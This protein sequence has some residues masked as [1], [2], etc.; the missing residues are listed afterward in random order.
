MKVQ[1][2]RGTINAAWVQTTV[3]ADWRKLT[4]TI[5]KL[6]ASS[7]RDL[8]VRVR[9]RLTD[10][11]LQ[12]APASAVT[13]EQK[14]AWAD[15]VSMSRS[16]TSALAGAV[17]EVGQ[18]LQRLNPVIV[19][20]RVALLGLISGNFRGLADKMNAKGPDKMR[21][22]WEAFGGN[23]ETLRAA[24]AK[25]AGTAQVIGF[26]PLL[27][28][29][30]TTLAQ[31]GGIPPGGIPAGRDTGG[32]T[33]NLAGLWKIAEPIILPLLA[34]LGIGRNEVEPTQQMS[35]NPPTGSAG[36]SSTGK[37]A[38]LVGGVVVAAVLLSG[39]RK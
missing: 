37:T 16:D 4:E 39:K 34:I 21:A 15:G 30:I 8:L 14:L 11:V 31:G 13:W 32:K 9:Q 23:Y 25:G 20:A 2:I 27:M 38:L 18:A 35:D 22:K 3:G 12:Y 5:A 24:I 36:G 1:A 17:E 6:P 28:P 10:Y 29:V 26:A 33:S 19:A 7:T